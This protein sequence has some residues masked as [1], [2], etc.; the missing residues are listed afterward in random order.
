MKYPEIELKK[1]KPHP[2]NPRT[3][4]DEQIA[5]IRASIEELGWGRPIIISSDFYILAGHGAALAAE[6]MGE[7]KVPYRQM[8]YK[9]DTP[10]AIAYMLVDNKLTDESDWD[11]GKLELA[12][13]ELK[14]EGFN[15]ELTGFDELELNAFNV[16][17]D[18]DS[19]I[20]PNRTTQNQ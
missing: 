18:F 15:L 20:T 13:D 8:A 17:P 6:A 9:H 4:T 12:F 1:L 7:K 14:L 5:K 2:K 19:S 16:D 10:E 11:Y 3:H